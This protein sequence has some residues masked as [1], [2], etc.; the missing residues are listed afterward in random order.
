MSYI[1]HPRYIH[2][3]MQLGKPKYL[4]EEE[5]RNAKFYYMIVNSSSDYADEL[6]LKSFDSFDI[7]SKMTILKH[8]SMNYLSLEIS[9]PLW[10]IRKIIAH[11]GTEQDRWDLIDDDSANVRTTI[12]TYGTEAQRGY[13]KNDESKQ[14][15]SAI[16]KMAETDELRD[17]V[18]NG[19]KIYPSMI[20][21]VLSSDTTN[22]KHIAKCKL[23][24]KRK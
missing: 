11:Y 4:S 18:F 19:K 12:A 13:L 8:V 16:Y 17:H 2:P 1:I 24:N 3:L 15:R 5:I 20:R 22:K 21:S 14:V 6:Y 7:D 23:L 9:N 10:I